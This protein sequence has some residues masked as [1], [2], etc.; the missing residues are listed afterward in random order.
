MKY[1]STVSPSRK[2][3]RMGLSITSPMPPVS[4]FWGLAIRPRIPASCRIWSRLPR[5]PESNIMNT[6]LNP[7]CDLASPST[8]ASAMSVLA[9]VQ[10]S[11]TLLY[12][13]PKVICPAPYARW[14]R[15]TRAGAPSRICTFSD[16]ISRSSTAMDTPPL[17]ACANPKSFSRSRNCTVSASPARRYASNTVPDSA[18]LRMTVF[19]N[20]SSA[21]TARGRM[22]LNST[23]PAVV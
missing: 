16:G 10:A 19:W 8:I 12:R 14:N 1:S 17:V 20:P 2:F 9:W 6:G 15:S 18:P 3:D 4:F 11:I 7:P 13:S 21:S 5:L 23:R 22:L